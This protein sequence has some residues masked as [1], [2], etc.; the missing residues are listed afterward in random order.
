MKIPLLDLSKQ[1]LNI[2]DMVD[3]VL[4]RVTES[5]QYISGPEVKAFESEIASYLGC[6]YA[7][8]C[9][10]GTD[11]LIISLKALGI[12]PGDEVIT[13]PFTFFATAEAISSV[14]ATPVFVDVN[15]D[16]YN[17]NPTLIESKVNSKTKA[18]IPVHIFGQSVEMDPIIDIAKKYSLYIIE[19]ACQAIGAEYKEKKV[20]TIGDIGCFSFFPTKNLGAFGD[21]GL[22]VTNSDKIATIV[23]GLKAH[24]S[25]HAGMLAYRNL[26]PG[27]D[28]SNTKTISGLD[29]QSAK[30]YNY[31]VG[32]NSRLDEIQAAV[33]RIKLVY[34][35]KWND[36]RR[37]LAA[38]YTKNLNETL[39]VTPKVSSQGREV[40]HLYI[41][42]TE[43]R[44]QLVK[45]LSMKGISTGVYYPVPLH[46]QTVYQHLNY[47]MGDLPV[48]EY[49]SHRTLALPLYPEM[50]QAEQD[51]I[52]DCI[53]QFESENQ[54][55]T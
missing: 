50:S 31:L 17:I 13:S 29:E 41:V 30:Y 24:G 32:Y 43:T 45:Y 19:D 5:T 52:I 16:T 25:G 55:G 22:M 8:S 40:F 38:R 44:S 54:D 3:N 28:E 47:K 11:A 49:L 42:Q 21:G 26:N 51:Y 4:I 34:L 48:S 14:G 15:Q 10:N 9:A 20:G 39:L 6:K 23:R 53:N 36:S 37:Q 46:L 12:G 1:Y 35:D 27:L 33:L 7:I 2:K 18:I